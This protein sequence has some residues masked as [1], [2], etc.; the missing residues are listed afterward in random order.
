M[1]I[2]IIQRISI[3]IKIW[4][5]KNQEHDNFK[6]ITIDFYISSND[7]VNEFNIIHIKW[8]VYLVNHLRIKML[9]EIDIINSKN[10]VFNFNDEK[11]IIDNCN[12][13]TL[14]VCILFKLRVHRNVNIFVVIVLFAFTITSI[15]FKFKNDFKLFRDRNFLF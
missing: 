1:F 11:F 6:Y 12:I 9:I 8:E 14:F 5:I 7:I 15:L 3:S 4:E 10:M 2:A 13:N